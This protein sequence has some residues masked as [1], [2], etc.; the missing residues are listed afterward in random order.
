MPKSKPSGAAVMTALVVLAVSGAQELPASHGGEEAGVQTR[1]HIEPEYKGQTASEWRAKLW[2][3]HSRRQLSMGGRDALDV[4]CSIARDGGFGV[5]RQ[6]LVN[7]ISEMDDPDVIPIL[8]RMVG[9]EVP[10]SSIICIQALAK[11]ANKCVAAEDAYVG[12]LDPRGDPSVRTLVAQHMAAMSIGYSAPPP[13]WAHR[14]AKRIAPRLLESALRDPW[15]PVRDA[16]IVAM[17]DSGPIATAAVE[18]LAEELRWFGSEPRSSLIVTLERLLAASPLSL[19]ARLLRHKAADVRMVAAESIRRTG[20]AIDNRVVSRLGGTLHDPDDQVAVAKIAAW[21]RLRVRHSG[22]ERVLA[23]LS[24][25]E[26]PAVS[27]A[28][29]RA[30]ES[31]PTR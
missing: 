30:L 25:H 6:V 20:D 10:E 19:R 28:A 2:D 11:M 7:V 31:L 26:S 14:R 27:K 23:A 3:E 29:R 24:Q 18:L 21:S 12:L 8:V 22:T 16:V 13:R 15:Q 4:V 1:G 5:L 17:C 9:D